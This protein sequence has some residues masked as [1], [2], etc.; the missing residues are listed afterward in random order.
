MKRVLNPTKDVS[1]RTRNAKGV[2]VSMFGE[3]T[4]ICLTCGNV[5]TPTRKNFIRNKFCSKSCSSKS[6]PSGMKGKKQSELQKAMMRAKCG[7][8]G[9]RWIADR[10]KVKVSD[11]ILND[12]RRKQWTRA[13]KMRDGWGC[14][15]ADENC[16]GQLEAHHILR[17]K[18]YPELRYEV[19]NGITLCFYHHPTKKEEEQKLVSVF[20]EIVSLTPT[21]YISEA[22]V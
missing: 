21:Y 12:P 15:I 13:V 3:R 5:F 6:H 18:D 11:R 19:N 1:F 20:K 8:K 2:F 4:K 10:S 17:W 14:R 7:E 16:A 22:T 9:T